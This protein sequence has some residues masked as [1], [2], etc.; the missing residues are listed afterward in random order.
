MSVEAGPVNNK[1][2]EDDD[3]VSHC[4]FHYLLFLLMNTHS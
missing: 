4:C 2:S 1:N 3:Q